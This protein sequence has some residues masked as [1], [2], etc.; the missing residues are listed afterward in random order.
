MTT[1]PSTAPAR[2]DRA[3]ARRLLRAD[4]HAHTHFSRDGFSSPEQFV[5]QAIKRGLNCVAVSDHNNILGAQ[6]VAKIAPFRV[7]IAEEIKTTEGEIIG[8]FLNDPV[9]KGL[10]PE[11]T[12][13]AI[14]DQGGLVCVPHPFDL[15]RRSPLKTSALLRILPD[16]DAVE[17]FNA[18]TMLPWDNRKSR[19]FALTHGKA[20]SAGSDTHWHPELGGTYVEIPE[21]EG[22]GDFLEALR[23]GCIHGEISNPIYHL[24]ST[25]A[26]LRWRLGFGVAP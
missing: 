1:T 22:P 26:K 19:A 15:F 24:I 4:L 25:I 8:W 2:T 5:R 20:L 14:K 7:I 16:V 18:R 23:A 3:S 17:A 10:T 13:R 11:E 6:E 12:V 21:F 9:P